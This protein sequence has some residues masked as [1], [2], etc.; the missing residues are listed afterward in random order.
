MAGKAP[1]TP[2]EEAELNRLWKKLVKLYHPDR[3]AHDPGEVGR[4]SV[5]P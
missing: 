5:E 2:D 3:F 1:L 4:D